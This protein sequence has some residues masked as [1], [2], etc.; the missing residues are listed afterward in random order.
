MLS[1]KATGHDMNEIRNEYS[2]M[3]INFKNIV[4]V[5][6]YRAPDKVGKRVGFVRFLAKDVRHPTAEFH[7]ILHQEALCTKAS[8]K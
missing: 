8:L 2:K 3:E 7:C 1:S 5:S 6:T 4:S